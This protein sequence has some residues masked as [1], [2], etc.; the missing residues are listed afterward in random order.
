MIP[1]KRTRLS[2]LVL[3][4]RRLFFWWLTGCVLTL[5]SVYLFQMNHVAMQGYVLTR[6]TQEN[7]S[8][9]ATMG[10]LDAQIARLE[11]REYIAK[12]SEKNQMVMR[13]RGRFVILKQTFTAQKESGL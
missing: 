4:T 13:E 9:T 8:L 10:Q 5:S 7:A 12:L 3:K 2:F 1:K 6:A 11:T